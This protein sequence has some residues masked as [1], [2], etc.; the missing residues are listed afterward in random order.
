M[1]SVKGMGFRLSA[2]PSGITDEERARRKVVK[3]MLAKDWVTR[4]NPN[5]VWDRTYRGHYDLSTHKK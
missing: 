2:M 3:D 4:F 1:K 5:E